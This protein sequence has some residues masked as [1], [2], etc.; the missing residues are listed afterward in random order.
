MRI[1]FE[2]LIKDSGEKLTKYKL[3]GEMADAGLFKNRKSAY[4]MILYHCS[5]KS[6][7]CDWELLKYLIQRFNKTGCEIIRWES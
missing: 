6:K 4:D 5:G 2:K 3:A 1:D 7:S